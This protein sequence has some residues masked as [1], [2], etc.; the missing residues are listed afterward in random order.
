VDLGVTG[1]GHKSVEVSIIRR[2]KE[3]RVSAEHFTADE[4]R[5]KSRRVAA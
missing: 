4:P 1:V 2:D 3:T 5:A